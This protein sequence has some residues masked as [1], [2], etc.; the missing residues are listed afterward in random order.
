MTEQPLPYCSVI[1]PVY[2]HWQLI[3]ALL[4]CLQR[5]TLGQAGFEVL[6]VD[7]GSQHFT[8]PAELPDN[9][10]ILKCATPGSYAA[11]NHALEHAKG[12]WLVFT[13]ADCLP[14]VEW[15]ERL[16]QCA[17]SLP[18][19]SVL[20]G[21]IRMQPSGACPSI[22]EMYDLVK[23]IPQAWYV[24]RGYAVT[25]NL[26]VP[27][28]LA[29]ELGGFEA[30]RLSGGDA[31]FVRRAVARGAMLHY[32]EQAVVAHPARDSWQAIA[33]KA[34][35]IK[36]GQLTAGSPGQR[37]LWLLRTFTPPLLAWYRFLLRSQQPWRYRLMASFLQT[38]LWGV[39]ALE[40]IRLLFQQGAERR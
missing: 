26:A 29:R 20:A 34:R 19:E 30:K 18:M 17:R 28:A 5:Q 32:V 16:M 38:R 35:R 11:R 39:E 6:L 10:R 24:S 3:P 40:A 13:D 7:N 27:L 2:E 14:E 37:A 23:G 8:P 1:V 12:P 25:A 31:D 15:L 22:Y 9:V 21:A 36:G 33:T 4:Q